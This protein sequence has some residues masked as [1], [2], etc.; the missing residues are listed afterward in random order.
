[1]GGLAHRDKMAA[2][3]NLSALQWS[4]KGNLCDLRIQKIN[5]ISKANAR[6]EFASTR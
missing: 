2:F 4:D 5:I 3:V 6:I 1:M